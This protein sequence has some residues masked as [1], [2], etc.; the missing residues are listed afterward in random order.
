MAILMTM[1][2]ALTPSIILAE[3]G[4]PE[5]PSGWEYKYAPPPYMGNVTLVFE[6]RYTTP[7]G[8]VGCAY[9]HPTAIDNRLYQAGHPYDYIE[10]TRAEYECSVY[11]YQFQS[12]TPQDI[13]GRGIDS[14]YCFGCPPG[15]FTIIAAHNLVYSPDKNSFTVDVIVMRL[16]GR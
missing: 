16:V 15:V 13:Q 12:H 3:G 10:F 4:G 6:P 8:T 2:L 5:P 14:N 9:M 1:I 11:D 7:K